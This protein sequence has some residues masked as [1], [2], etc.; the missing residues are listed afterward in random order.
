MGKSAPGHRR[1]LRQRAT[2]GQKR[3]SGRRRQPRSPHRVRLRRG[4]GASFWAAGGPV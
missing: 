1:I 3:G 4:L 2:V